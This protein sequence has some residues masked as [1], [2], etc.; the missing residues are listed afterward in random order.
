MRARKVLHFIMLLCCGFLLFA[1]YLQHYQ[2]MLPCPL[3]VIQR[4]AYVGIMFFCLVGRL[5]PFIR[6]ASF[7]ALL[8]AIGGGAAAMLQL[9]AIKNPAVQC[10]RDPL[11]AA[12]NSLLPAKWLPS[13][14]KAEGYCGEALDRII[15]LT[16]PEWSLVWCALFACFFLIIVLRYRG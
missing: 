13:L 10:G 6:M 12:V 1:F 5:T 16:P 11:E 7:L 3:C 15:G 8:A 9:Q 14:F 2:F 4:Y